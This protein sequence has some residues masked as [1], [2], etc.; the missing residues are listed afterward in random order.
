MKNDVDSLFVDNNTTKIDIKK[1]STNVSNINTVLSKRLSITENDIADI[2]NNIVELEET[3]NNID[4]SNVDITPIIS[5]IAYIKQNINDVSKDLLKQ[6]E[7]NLSKINNL[8][9]KDILFTNNISEI[10][11]SII[12]LQQEDRHIFNILSELQS[13]DKKIL[14]DIKLIK[15]DN[16]KINDEIISIKEKIEYLSGVDVDSFETLEGVNRRLN[17]LESADKSFQ[18]EIDRLNETIKD[19]VNTKL[20]WIIL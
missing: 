8:T 4:I 19:G 10:K 13:I 6:I 1:I 16:E 5:D 17:K 18:K 15:E 2:K 3:I 12:S 11:Q 9:S 7:E 14:S 20:K